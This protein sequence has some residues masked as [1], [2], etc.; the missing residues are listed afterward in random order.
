MD[1]LRLYET[2]KPEKWTAE[3]AKSDWRAGQYLAE[4]IAE[5][6]LR[7]LCGETTE[8]LLLADNDRLVSFCTIAE[9]DEIADT[10]LRPWLGFV[11]TFPEY[12]GKRCIGRLIDF[13]CDIASSQGYD[14]L[15]VSTDQ[16]GL[17]ENFGFVYTCTKKMSIYG[18]MSMIYKRT[19]TIQEG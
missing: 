5:N 11:Y 13:A 14:T 12:R 9:Q 3:I 1:I 8:V 15:Y 4:L 18:E 16:R 17:Y 2:P 19:L 10:D 7:E 6:R